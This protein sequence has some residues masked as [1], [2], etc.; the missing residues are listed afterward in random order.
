M[1]ERVAQFLKMLILKICLLIINLLKHIEA[2][3]QRV[4]YSKNNY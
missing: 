4:N 1:Y 2:I 3:T